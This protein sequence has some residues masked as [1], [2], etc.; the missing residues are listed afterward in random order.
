MSISKEEVM[1]QKSHLE[2]LAMPYEL[3]EGISEILLL[4]NDFVNVSELDGFPMWSYLGKSSH[5]VNKANCR[6]GAIC[7]IMFDGLPRYLFHKR[8]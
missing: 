5:P 1:L 4:P 8:L 3:C 2:I 7:I 6:R